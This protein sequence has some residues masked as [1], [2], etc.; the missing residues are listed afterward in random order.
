MELYLYF[1]IRLNSVLHSLSFVGGQLYSAFVGL[2]NIKRSLCILTDCVALSHSSAMKSYRFNPQCVTEIWYLSNI[3]WVC[4]VF[5]SSCVENLVQKWAVLSFFMA[6]LSCWRHASDHLTPL[7]PHYFHLL[8][9][10]H[11]IIEHCILFFLL[12]ALLNK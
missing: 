2:L 6:F 1:L 11:F 8:F 3:L 5:V 12:T 10:D 4:L 9:T 7:L